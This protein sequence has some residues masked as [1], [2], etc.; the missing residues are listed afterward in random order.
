MQITT[1]RKDQNQLI[2]SRI[3]VTNFVKFLKKEWVCYS[4]PGVYP[5]NWYIFLLLT[6]SRRV[7]KNKTIIHFLEKNLNVKHAAYPSK[8]AQV[9]PTAQTI[10]LE[11]HSSISV[12][13]LESDDCFS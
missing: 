13:I 3:I 2:I 8:L 11:E 7:K 10:F 6:Q 9:W 4:D 12:Q 5:E 1:F